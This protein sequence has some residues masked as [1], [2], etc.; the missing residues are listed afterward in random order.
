MSLVPRKAGLALITGLAVLAI[1]AATTGTAQ[2]ASPVTLAEDWAPFSRCPV[3]D[4]AMLAADGTL[5]DVASCNAA[6]SP[7]GSIKLGNITAAT[8]DSNLQFGLVLNDNTGQGP[9]VPPSGGAITA[10]PVQIPGGLLGLMCP[11]DIPA[12]SVLCSE[13]IGDSLNAVTAVVEP[14]GDPSGFSLGAGLATGQPIL[15][16]PVRIQLQ[17]PLLGSACFI[18]SDADPIVLH[19][20]NLSAPATSF[21]RYDANGAPD[22]AGAFASIVLTGTQGD[23]TFAVPGASGCGPAGV[24]DL[25]IDL[26]SG[27]PSPSGDNSLML[28]NS[29]T[30]ALGGFAV[31]TQQAPTEGQDLAAAWHAAVQP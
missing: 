25:A 26:K 10:A 17:N 29:V 9:I 28:D 22:P 24:A 4:P 8:G 13:I 27:L 11:S 18:G 16:L 23:N 12:M 1:P 19:P 31:P 7:S 15:T 21:E 6:D 20:E 3:D 30:H 2:A 5:T 14:A